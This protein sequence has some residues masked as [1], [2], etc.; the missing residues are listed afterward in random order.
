MRKS[1]QD[2]Q[3]L[4]EG[5]NYVVRW[6]ETERL[7]DGSYKKVRRSKALVPV[8]GFRKSEAEELARE[9]IHGFGGVN[10][11]AWTVRDFVELE[12]FVNYTPAL[13]VSTQRGYA[14]VW[15]CH[16]GVIPEKMRLREVKTVDAQAYLRSIA[17]RKKLTKRSLAH[18]KAFFSGVF[19]EALRQGLIPGPNPWTS[20]RLPNEGGKSNETS[21]YTPE[22]IEQHLLVLPEPA[23]TAVLLACCTGLRRS[24]IQGLRWSDYNAATS[25]LTVNRAYLFG[26]YKETKSKASHAPLPVV[27]VLKRRLDML[28]AKLGPMMD[29]PMFPSSS[30]TPMDLNN[31]TNRVIRPTFEKHGMRFKGW[32]SYRRG[33]GTFLYSKGIT[34][35]VIQKILRHS[36]VNVSRNHYIKV[37]DSETKAAMESVTF[38]LESEKKE[39]LQ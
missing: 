37:V 18:I 29:A 36:D 16:G 3:V 31:F 34:D 14:Y 2:G 20:T 30:G 32:H 39:V 4:K 13:S 6:R 26:E 24:E 11:L 9:T 38:G 7:P 25:E 5:G 10:T 28:L 33:L 21:A 23:N 22:E 1:H 12:Y 17:A 15:K 27:P 19:A 35:L 8:K